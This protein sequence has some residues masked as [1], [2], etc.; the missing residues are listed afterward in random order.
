MVTWCNR[1]KTPE[2]TQSLLVDIHTQ[3]GSEK[4]AAAVPCAQYLDLR[5]TLNVENLSHF[6]WKFPQCTAPNLYLK[7]AGTFFSH[8]ISLPSFHCLSSLEFRFGSILSPAWLLSNCTC[9]SYNEFL[10]EP[11]E[12]LHPLGINM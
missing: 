5:L 10:I 7:A 2:R 1:E 4:P 9:S 6:A 8:F 3:Q 11:R 12:N